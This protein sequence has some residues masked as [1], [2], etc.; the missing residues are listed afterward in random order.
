MT[1]GQGPGRVEYL[2][3]EQWPGLEK[4]LLGGLMKRGMQ[5][6][7]ARD[8]VQDVW[9]A[10]HRRLGQQP[11]L[12]TPHLRSYAWTTARNKQVDHHRFLA[13]RPASELT[14][15]CGPVP[16]HDM[17][18]VER[19]LLQQAA[20][21]HVVCQAGGRF[22]QR[23]TLLAGGLPPV[24]EIDLHG[25][26]R[27]A[28]YFERLIRE[29][30]AARGTRA[31]AWKKFLRM[32]A[33]ARGHVHVLYTSRGTARAPGEAAA[34]GGQGAG[35]GNRGKDDGGAFS[36][37]MVGDGRT[38]VRGLFPRMA[39]EKALVHARETAERVFD[40]TDFGGGALPYRVEWTPP[41]PPNVASCRPSSPLR[42]LN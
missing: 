36:P 12:T 1:P 11:P 4:E 42:L 16:A 7:D 38:L 14:E 32:V 27:L 5:E 20:L 15:E 23:V 31:K 10:L 8:I 21:Q 25:I 9:L 34:A 29:A 30:P 40:G 13:R 6:A 28:Y 2:L 3:N 37:D 39:Q 35:D 22:P 17:T 26:T 33:A 19:R 41:R 24:Q 18:E